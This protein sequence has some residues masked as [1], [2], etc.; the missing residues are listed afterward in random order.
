MNALYYTAPGIFQVESHKS[1][2]RTSQSKFLSAACVVPTHIHNREFISTFPLV[3]GHEIVG[4][5]S[6]C[7]PSVQGFQAGDRVVADPGVTS[8]DEAA[9][10]VE[11]SCGPTGLILAQL[12][13]LNGAVKLIIAAPR[14]PKL[15]LARKLEIADEYVELERSSSMTQWQKLKQMYPYGFDAVVEATGNEPI[16]SESTNHVRRGGKLLI[17][18]VYADKDRVH[19]SPEILG[20][21]AQAHCFPRAVAYLEN[22][23]LKTEGLISHMM[24]LDEYQKALDTMASRKC[25]KIAIRPS[26]STAAV[27]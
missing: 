7:G 13:K 2:T 14:G 4:T 26:L 19:W 8:T 21:F 3:P 15:A 25:I 17:Y 27:A 24:H 11:P 12:L 5:I 9:T 10:L 23:R 18:G 20:S 6:Q 16:A 22:G 1:G